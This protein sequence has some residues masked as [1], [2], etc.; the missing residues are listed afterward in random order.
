MPAR[1]RR[2]DASERVLGT[3]GRPTMARPGGGAESRRRGR[4]APSGGTPPRNVRD[5]GLGPAKRGEP[6]GGLTRDERLQTGPHQRGLLLNAGD[7]SR[8]L[9][10]AIV[11]DQRRPHMHQYA[12]LMHMRQ[13]DPGRPRRRAA[14]YNQSTVRYLGRL[15][16]LLLVPACLYCQQIVPADVPPTVVG[17]VGDWTGQTKTART[18]HALEFGSQVSG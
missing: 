3:G 5:F 6:S 2:K 14:R 9:Q 12:S 10:K 18:A 7:R 17:I 4:R 16:L 11:D 13:A 8:A 15:F 1:R